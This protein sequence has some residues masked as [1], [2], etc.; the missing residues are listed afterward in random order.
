L[1]AQTTLVAQA[2]RLC[3]S[4]AILF[5]LFIIKPNFFIAAQAGTLALIK[6]NNFASTRGF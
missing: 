3:L 6:K 5:L 2:I 4:Y 1:V